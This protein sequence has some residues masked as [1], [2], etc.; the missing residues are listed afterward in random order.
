[1]LSETKND[2]MTLTYGREFEKHEDEY[3][4][5]YENGEDFYLLFDIQYISEEDG[6]KTMSYNDIV[7]YFERISGYKATFCTEEYTHYFPVRLYK[8]EKQTEN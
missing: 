5:L 1:M 3:K 8:F 7:G 4:K 6:P 2:F